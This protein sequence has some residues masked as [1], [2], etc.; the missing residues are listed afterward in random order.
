MSVLDP[1]RRFKAAWFLP[2]AATQSGSAFLFA[3]QGQCTNHI[4]REAANLHPEALVQFHKLARREGGTAM[5]RVG[6]VIGALA[7]VLLPLS[8]IAAAEHVMAAR[9]SLKG[10][11]GP[12]ALPKGAE[13]AVIAGDPGKEGPLVYRIR[14]PGGCKVKHYAHR[15][16]A[17]VSVISGTFN[18]EMG[19][20]FN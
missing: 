5:T 15:R 14:V 8:A 9:A 6:P 19:D 18:L 16:D 13:L 2:V 11:H 1:N 4:A 3:G 17:N 10:G 7:L 12:A 20:K